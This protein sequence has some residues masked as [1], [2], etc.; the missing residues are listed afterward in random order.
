MPLLPRDT[1]VPLP[2]DVAILQVTPRHLLPE[3]ASCVDTLT[4]AVIEADGDT[5]M[6]VPPPSVREL[7]TG[8]L[9][10]NATDGNQRPT[11]AIKR[12]ENSLK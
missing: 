1:Q 9:S 6:V 8:V 2:D 11:E 10:A 12:P 4:T 7:T 3:L 5:V